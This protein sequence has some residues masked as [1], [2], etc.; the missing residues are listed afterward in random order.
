MNEDLKEIETMTS[1]MI[2]LSNRVHWA[3]HLS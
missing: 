3:I 1:T 2:N